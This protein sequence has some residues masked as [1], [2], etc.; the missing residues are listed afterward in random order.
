MRE[1]NGSER[2]PQRTPIRFDQI[3]CDR[4]LG[5]LFRCIGICGPNR[6]NTECLI[7]P[8]ACLEARRIAYRFYVGTR[9]RTRSEICK[10]QMQ[11]LASRNTNIW[12]L[13][14]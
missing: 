4:L 9:D 8:A 5:L 11:M 6:Q 3:L 12:D 13:R 14:D 2:P 1:M 7:E 10:E